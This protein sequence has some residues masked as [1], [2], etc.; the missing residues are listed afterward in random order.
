V[1]SPSKRKGSHPPL[2]RKKEKEKKYSFD[3]EGR[4][5]KGEPPRRTC[6]SGKE[7]KG[8]GSGPGKKKKKKSAVHL[9]SPTKN[10]EGKGKGV[11]ELVP[12]GQEG[13]GEKKGR[14]GKERGGTH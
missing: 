9:L 7:G 4:K 3:L 8:K 11:V 14:N 5:E 10:E 12:R 2:L 6:F 1:L 13:K